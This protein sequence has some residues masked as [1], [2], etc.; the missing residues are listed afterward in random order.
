[1]KRVTVI[2]S[3]AAIVAA[4]GV[5][6]SLPAHAQFPAALQEAQRTSD[7]AKASQQRIDDLDD[8]TAELLNQFRA[9]QRQLDA[10]RRYN[11][12]VSG[13]VNNQERL[14][15]RLQEDI[16]NV[17]TL[18]QAVKPLMGDMVAAFEKFVDADMPF[19]LEG[20]TG[21]LRR[22]ERLREVFEDPEQSAAQKYRTIIEAYKLENE[23]GRTINAYEG[24]I[25]VDG[26][27][28]TGEYLQIGRISLIF[29]TAD[30]SVLKVWNNEAKAWED[31][32]KSYLP[33]IAVAMRI[34]KQQ[35]APNLFAFPIKRL[36]AAE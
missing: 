24:T 13:T 34:A 29:K 3:I 2:G 5:T 27:A 14:I 31:L 11:E 23:F 1:M 9:D 30:D 26:V 32:A 25:D 19:N 12:D 20:P 35:A 22:S 15:A 6:A 8:Q 17:A 18:Q 7:E 10:L 21:R 33:D 28:T 36:A 4:L 16:S